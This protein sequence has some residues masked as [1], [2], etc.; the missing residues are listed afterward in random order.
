MTTTRG[1]PL[2]QVT[3]D[4]LEEVKSQLQEIVNVVEARL[5]AVERSLRDDAYTVTNLTTTRSLDVTAATTSDVAEVLGTLIQDLIDANQLVGER[6]F[7]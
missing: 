4:D 2:P 5:V 3:G 1:E 6:R 7:D